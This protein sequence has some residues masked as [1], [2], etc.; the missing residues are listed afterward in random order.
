MLGGG[1]HP[2]WIGRSYSSAFKDA[3]TASHSGLG[4]QCCLL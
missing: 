3:L 1:E 2:R 4:Y